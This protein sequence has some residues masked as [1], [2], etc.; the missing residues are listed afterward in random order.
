VGLVQRDIAVCHEILL[1][2]LKFIDHIC[3]SEQITYTLISGTLLGA[4]RHKGFIPWDDDAD[5][6][7]TRADYE[8]L[9]R[10]VPRYLEQHDEFTFESDGGRVFRFGLKN[11]EQ[12]YGAAYWYTFADVFVADN[13]PASPLRYRLHIAYLKLLQS[14]MK[15]KPR[16]KNYGFLAK[17]AAF[18]LSLFGRCFPISFLQKWY[19]QVS[20]APNKRETRFAWTKNGL[21]KH[22]TLKAERT[23]FSE[24]TRVPFEDTVLSA[25]VHAAEL[26]TLLYGADYME[27]PPEHLRGH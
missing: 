15:R 11:I 27:P 1:K 6:A 26:L 10:V 8:H 18:F 21:Y 23:Y 9:K 24:V 17:V 12:T 16:Y 4:V 14:I 7:M 20:R 2:L 22:L 13:L 3:V 25:S 19:E 5:I